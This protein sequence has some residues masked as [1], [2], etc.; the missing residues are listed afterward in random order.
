MGRIIGTKIVGFLS[1]P[2][3]SKISD[4]SSCP[5]I[6]FLSRGPSICLLTQLRSYLQRGAGHGE[7]RDAQRQL[8]TVWRDRAGFEDGV[9][10]CPVRVQDQNLVRAVLSRQHPT[11]EMCTIKSRTFLSFLFEFHFT[12]FPRKKKK[13]FPF[14]MVLLLDCFIWFIWE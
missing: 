5:S 10:V 7:R 9:R 3:S 6:C 1:G 12:Y 11:H 14:S 13:R 2:I 4:K 8:L